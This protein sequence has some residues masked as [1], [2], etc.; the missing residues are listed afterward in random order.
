MGQKVHPI[1]F[2]LGINRSWDSIYDGINLGWAKKWELNGWMRN[3][4]DKAKNK[5]LWKRL[6]YQ[7]SRHDITFRWIRGHDGHNENE[8]CDQLANTAAASSSLVNWL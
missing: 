6:L 7:N 5:D 3:K 4:K 2:R 1:G 8:R